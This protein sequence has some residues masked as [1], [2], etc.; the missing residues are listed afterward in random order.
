[1][2]IPEILQALE[3]EQ[4]I[5]QRN[6]P[7]SELWKEASENIHRLTKLLPP[8]VEGLYCAYC[9]RSVD[10][11]TENL[12]A[13]GDGLFIHVHCGDDLRADGQLEVN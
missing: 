12:E 5:Q 10:P 7:S 6:P 3:A 13:V 8:P 1:V 9:R 4:L 11:E 2:T